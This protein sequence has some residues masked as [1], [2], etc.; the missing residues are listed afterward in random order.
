M[1]TL[2]KYFLEFLYVFLIVFAVYAVPMLLLLSGEGNVGEAYYIAVVPIFVMINVVWY[3]IAQRGGYIFS[4]AAAMIVLLGQGLFFFR[5]ASNPAEAELSFRLVLGVI[6]ALLE[7]GVAVIV[8]VLTAFVNACR[9]WNRDRKKRLQK[10]AD[11]NAIERITSFTIDHDTLTPGIYISRVDGDVT[12]YD[13]RTRTPNGGAYMD[14]RTAHSVEHMFATYVRNSALSDRVIYFGPM[15]CR[16]GFYLLV[17][18]VA[19]KNVLTLVK[20]TL[21]K[22]LAHEGEVFGASRKECGNYLD[23]DLADAKRE[24]RAYLAVLNEKEEWSFSYE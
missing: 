22:I 18:D 13:L 3:T 15:G 9:T 21:E 17:R 20:D 23:L 24:C 8:C 12:T 1:R 7:G 10:A 6:A 11:N 2:R 19:P 4:V 16:T 5:N 14:T